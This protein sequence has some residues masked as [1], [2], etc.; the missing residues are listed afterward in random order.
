M[1]LTPLALNS[2]VLSHVHRTPLFLSENLAMTSRSFR[3]GRPVRPAQLSRA[4]K[5]AELLEQRTMLFAVSAASADAFVDSIGINTHF[6]YSSPTNN[7]YIATAAVTT[8]LENSGIRYIRDSFNSSTISRADSFWNSYGIQTEVVSGVGSPVATSDLNAELGRTWIAGIEGLNEPDNALWVPAG[9]TRTP[10]TFGGTRNWQKTLYDD[11]TSIAPSVP[12]LSS[13]M[14]DPSMSGFLSDT[15]F[16]DAN[17]HIYI[18]GNPGSYQ[19]QSTYL[20]A[21]RSMMP[22]GTTL[23]IIASEEGYVTSTSTDSRN[24][25]TATQADYIPRVLTENFSAGISRTYLYEL[26]NEYDEPGTLEANWGLLNYDGSPKPAFTEVENLISLLG[27]GSYSASTHTWTKPSFTPGSLDYTLGGNTTNVHQLLLQKSNGDFYLALWQEVNNASGQTYVDTPAQSVTVNLN[28]MASSAALYSLSST[29]PTATYLDTSSITFNVDSQVVLLKITPEGYQ[30]PSSVSFSD[31]FD[32]DATGATPSG[33]TAASGT[34]TVAANGT[35]HYAQNTSA[36]GTNLALTHAI[37]TTLNSSFS[38]DFDLAWQ[39][40]GSAGSFGNYNYT[41]GI[42]LIN[43]TTHTG[44]RI[45]LHQGDS[46]VVGNDSTLTQIYKVTYTTSNVLSSSTLLASGSGYNKAGSSTPDW[47]HVRVTRDATTGDI[48]VYEDADGDGE[49]RVAARANDSSYTGFS[50]VALAVGNVTGTANAR[51]NNLT[52]AT[53]TVTVATTD[54]TAGEVGPDDGFV[55]FT[56]TGPTT[57]PLTVNYRLGGSATGAD[58]GLSTTGSLTIPAGS[59]SATLSIVPVADGIVEG[60]E[61]L[62]L[63]VLEAAAYHVGQARS[64]E[65]T[66]LDAAPDLVVTSVTWTGSTTAGSSG[67]F[68]ITVKNQGTTATS[69]TVSAGIRFNNNGGYSATASTAS[70]I[71]P[72]ASVVLT[73]GTYTITGSDRVIRA[74]VDSGDSSPTG[75]IPESRGDNNVLYSFIHITNKSATDNFDAD[76]TGAAPSGWTTS[77]SD[78]QVK[79]AGTQKF[80]ENTT[81]AGASSKLTKTLPA[82]VS[83]TNS[84]T[85]DANLAWRWG[86][87]ASGGYGTYSLDSYLDILDGSGNGYRIVFHQGNSNN[88]GNNSVLTQIYHVTASVRDASPLAQGTGFNTPGWQ[89]LGLTAPNWHAVRIVFDRGDNRISVLGDLDGL[90]HYSLLA[91]A[92]GLSA[93]S[94]FTQ[95]SLGADV[96]N[97]EG[98]EWDNIDFEILS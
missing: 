2:S 33:W 46:G 92:T 12:I 11:A 52:F 32:A 75:A 64:G 16:D 85:L 47:S 27:E 58:V 24:V 39:F 89:T 9:D 3:S 62:S 54:G 25:S 87:S 71:N 73:T 86:G 20:P 63:L 55:V 38:V 17:M 57:G 1:L 23:P 8:A 79:A 81:A 77:G 82:S 42:D 51:F 53:P 35:D 44:Y 66:I 80:L 37:G 84:F 50:T 30:A 74:A 56:R 40:G 14:A 70:A 21:A 97:T 72:G 76:T 94:S 26:A 49:F 59:A 48:L 93:P 18:N 69:G 60:D 7:A 78:W 31:N 61:K 28:K 10:S 34:W 90:G 6:G 5:I 68:Q 29:S 67:Q 83:S 41:S 19:L 88:A 96:N 95:F 43:P 15:T 98:P 45:L 65:V 4:L 91:Q 22:S 36:S 13:A